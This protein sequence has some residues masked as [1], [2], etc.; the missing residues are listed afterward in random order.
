MADAPASSAP[1]GSSAPTAETAA[2]APAWP[3]RSARPPGSPLRRRRLPPSSSLPD[4]TGRPPVNGPNGEGSMPRG[5]QV[6]PAAEREVQ[7]EHVRVVDRVEGPLGQEGQV[8]AV[9]GE[10]RVGVDEP[11]VGDVADL[12]VS[13]PGQPDPA[14][15][16]GVR[17]DQASQRESGENASP[18]TRPLS[19]LA[20]SATWPDATSTTDRPPSCAAT[21]IRVP[22]GAAASSGPS[23]TRRAAIRRGGVGLVVRRRRRADLDRVG[24]IGV[25]DPDGLPRVAEHARQPGQRCREWPTARAPGRPGAPASAPCRAP[26]PRWP[27]RYVAASAR[28]GGR[29]PRSASARGRSQASRG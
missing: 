1:D 28:P 23:R 18:V 5:Q 7:V 6:R 22:S 26:Q 4:P 10:R 24:A 3:R 14:Q 12:P 27:G 15:R 29:P 11:A 16:R 2:P 25:D 9:A 20:S 17:C 8:P 19:D 13:Q 21:A